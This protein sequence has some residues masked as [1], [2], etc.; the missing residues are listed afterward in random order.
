MGTYGGEKYAGDGRV[1]E[2]TASREGVGC[3]ACRGR[4]DAAVGLDDGEEMCVAVEFEI[5][6]VGG[7]AAVY[8]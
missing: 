6:D 1:G 7:G 5:G 3:A 4:D 2:R 8:D